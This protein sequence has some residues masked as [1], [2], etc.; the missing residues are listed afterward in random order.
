M[1][2]TANKLLYNKSVLRAHALE[3][4]KNKLVR[5]IAAWMNREILPEII[6]AIPGASLSKLALLRNKI[7]DIVDLKDLERLTVDELVQ[8]ARVEAKFTVDNLAGVTD[9]VNLNKPTV[10]YLKSVIKSRPFEGEIMGDWFRDLEITTQEN[11]YRSIQKGLAMGESVPNLVD[12]VRGT[13]SAAFGDGTWEAQLRNAKAI[14]RTA[15]NH[16]SSVAREETYAA[17]EDIIDGVEWVSTLDTRTT[18]MCMA[19]D[20]K[21][22]PIG[23]GP[24]PPGHWN[25]RSTTVPVVKKMTGVSAYDS[26]GNEIVSDGESAPRQN[27]GEWIKDQSAADQDEAL[28][29]TRAEM[30][31]EG[32][33]VD[34]FVNNQWEL[35]TLKELEKK[36]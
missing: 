17:N 4:Y 34:S 14:V 10:G 28:G 32:A 5:D 12:R 3:R 33:T 8:F 19:L 31:R 1:T 18:E 23:E 27:Y 16:V 24:R 13:A 2:T 20:G 9:G 22:F 7:E 35:M 36:S 6:A 25:C 26:R 15:A 21:M 29:P 30:L 11:L